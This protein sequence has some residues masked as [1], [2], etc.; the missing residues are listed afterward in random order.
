MTVGY[1]CRVTIS[2]TEEG[3]DVLNVAAKR[4]EM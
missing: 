2:K 4:R 1:W 3:A